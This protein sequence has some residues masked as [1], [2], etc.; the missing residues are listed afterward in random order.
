[1]PKFLDKS[2]Q[3]YLRAFF[4]ISCNFLFQILSPTN[5]VLFCHIFFR[6]LPIC[7]MYCKILIANK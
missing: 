4:D 2:P 3:M 6:H 7:T 1:M 5:S